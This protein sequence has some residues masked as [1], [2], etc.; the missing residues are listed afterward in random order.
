[1]QP[2]ALRPTVNEDYA[3]A[4]CCHENFDGQQYVYFGC[5]PPLGYQN[6]IIN[7]HIE[8]KIPFGDPIRAICS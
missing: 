6:A 2:I 5:Q 3:S 1:M 7:Q 8:M 4:A